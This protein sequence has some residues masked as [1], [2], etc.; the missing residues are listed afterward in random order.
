MLSA[1]RSFPCTPSSVAAARHWVADVL[2]PG[3]NGSS[4]TDDVVFLVSE[5]ASNAIVHAGSPFTVRISESGVRL[6]V[7]VADHD[8]TRPQLRRP[9][10]DDMRGRGLQC[11]AALAASWGTELIEGDGKA[12]WFEVMLSERD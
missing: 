3:W 9:T 12:V 7:S 6:R 11:V 5:L 2:S 1:A 10:S 4:T 8:P